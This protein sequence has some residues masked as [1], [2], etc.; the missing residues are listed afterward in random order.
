MKIG[1]VRQ[2]IKGRR[3]GVEQE[4]TR[5]EK[6]RMRKVNEDRKSTESQV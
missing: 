2:E 4:A 6:G 5:G 1:R 3:K